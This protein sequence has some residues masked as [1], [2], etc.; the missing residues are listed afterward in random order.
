MGAARLNRQSNQPQ[1]LQ[2]RS[3]VINIWT[4][5]ENGVAQLDL[6]VNALVVTTREL[7]EQ[8]EILGAEYVYINPANIVAMNIENPPP[9]PLPG[10]SLVED[11]PEDEEDEVGEDE[12]EGPILASGPPE[13][14]EE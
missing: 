5:T 13:L 6:A 4:V 3:R 10:L 12:D 9:L 8:C 11:V 1:T 2:A 14:S 7:A